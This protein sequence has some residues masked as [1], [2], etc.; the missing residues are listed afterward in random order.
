MQNTIAKNPDLALLQRCKPIVDQVYSLQCAIINNSEEIRSLKI[1][2]DEVMNKKR[3]WIYVLL[4]VIAI[5]TFP[6][7]I[8]Y[9]V[10]YYIWSKKKKTRQLED[11]SKRISDAEHRKNDVE[12]IL[13]SVLISNEGKFALGNIPKDYFYPNAVERFIYYFENGHV[14]TMKEAVKE[15]DSYMHNCRMEYEASRA[16]DANERAAAA[17]ERTAQAAEETARNTASIRSSVSTIEQHTNNI[18]FWT[19]YYGSLNLFR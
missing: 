18:N 7:G 12:Q 9:S 19:N 10:I 17:A 15:Y 8:L 1:Q 14:D 16:A 3:T 2:H 11:L 6:L 13:S 4:V 5:I